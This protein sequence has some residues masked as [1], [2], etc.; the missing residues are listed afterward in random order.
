MRNIIM[1]HVLA[2][3][4]V[5]SLTLGTMAATPTPAKAQPPIPPDPAIVGIMAQALDAGQYY[6]QYG[7]GGQIRQIV[8]VAEAMG[9]PFVVQVINDEITY[10]SYVKALNAAQVNMLMTNMWGWATKTYSALPAATQVF[11]GRE[12]AVRASTMSIEL[13]P[14]VIAYIV[15]SAS[16][17]Q[18][19]NSCPETAITADEYVRMSDLTKQICNPTVLQ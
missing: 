15:F 3:V 12:V 4:I 1:G 7:S 17:S 16:V 19:A 11:I 6:V 14:A 10:A 8:L 5:A 2:L 9:M 18:S 13:A